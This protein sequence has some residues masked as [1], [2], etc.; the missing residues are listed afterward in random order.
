MDKILCAALQRYSDQTVE[1]AQ[2]QRNAKILKQA[3]LHTV[4]PTLC[5]S[6][7]FYYINLKIIIF[8]KYMYMLLLLLFISIVFVRFTFQ[9]TRAQSMNQCCHDVSPKCMSM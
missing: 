9:S 5:A 8:F 1:R 7:D 4:A 2:R 3:I 6:G